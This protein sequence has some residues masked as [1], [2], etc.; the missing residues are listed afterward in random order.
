MSK[1]LQIV[2]LAALA[3]GLFG[4]GLLLG[5]FID[6]D[7]RV[8]MEEV[9]AVG[10]QATTNLDSLTLSGTLSAEQVTSTDDATVTDDLTVGGDAAVTGAVSAATITLDSQDFVSATSA[11]TISGVLTD[12]HLIYIQN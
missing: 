7:N 3:V 9:G 4:G 1:I 2:A 12:V 8:A 11:I 6:L 5:V 10:A